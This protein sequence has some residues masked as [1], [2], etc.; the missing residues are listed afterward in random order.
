MNISSIKRQGYILEVVK[1]A[2]SVNKVNSRRLSDQLDC[3]EKTII[4][5]IQSLNYYI[6]DHLLNNKYEAFKYSNDT[7]PIYWDFSSRSYKIRQDVSHLKLSKILEYLID[8]AA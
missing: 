3:S 7:D 4:R 8:A 5:E 1:Q 6:D 2:S